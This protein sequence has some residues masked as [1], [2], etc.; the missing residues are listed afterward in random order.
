MQALV[1]FCA[2]LKMSSGPIAHQEKSCPDE[3][4]PLK[5]DY[6]RGSAVTM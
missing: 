5:E 4:L 1:Y 6:G 3:Q 2:F